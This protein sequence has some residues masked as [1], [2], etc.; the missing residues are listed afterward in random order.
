MGNPLKR[1]GTPLLPERI[2]A[3]IVKCTEEIRLK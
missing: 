1:E 2:E 3:L